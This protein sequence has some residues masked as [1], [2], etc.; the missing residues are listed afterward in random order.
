MSEDL[1]PEAVVRGFIN[2]MHSWEISAWEARRQAQD[3]P[4]PASYWPHVKAGLDLV[5]AGFCTI[6]DRPHG[7]NASFQHPTEYDPN[8]E[9]I[10]GSEIAGDKAYVDTERRALLGGGILRYTL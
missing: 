3:T 4:D 2:A 9:Q 1:S 10:I 8:S 7:R 5:Y 6:R